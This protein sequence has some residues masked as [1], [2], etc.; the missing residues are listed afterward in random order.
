MD[1]FLSSVAGLLVDQCLQYPIGTAL[2]FSL[3]FYV[4]VPIFTDPGHSAR[5]EGRRWVVSCLVIFVLLG[6]SLTLF[7]PALQLTASRI[8]FRPTPSCS[9]FNNP[10]RY[11]AFILD[12][13]NNQ[14]FY[15]TTTRAVEDTD[16]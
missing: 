2:V 16:P 15:V 4:L 3:G 11:L 6:V 10:A 8:I 13:S 7:I 5:T 9:T 12:D 1:E 14:V